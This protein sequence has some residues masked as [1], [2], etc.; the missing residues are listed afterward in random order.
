MASTPRPICATSWP[1]SPT[2]RSTGSTTSSRGPGPLRR[3]PPRPPDPDLRSVNP[4]RPRPAPY[5]YEQDVVA[6]AGR[7]GPE[8]VPRRRTARAGLHHERGGIG[9]VGRPAYIAVIR[10]R[11]LVAV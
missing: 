7:P 11:Q 5:A 10:R 2:I 9:L 1:A 8:D 3:A 4:L 6:R